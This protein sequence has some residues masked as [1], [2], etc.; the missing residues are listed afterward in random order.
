MILYNNFVFCMLLGIPIVIFLSTRKNKKGVT[1]N[2][3]FI[4]IFLGLGVI[5][6]SLIGFFAYSELSHIIAEPLEMWNRIYFYIAADLF[7]FYLFTVAFL[8]YAEKNIT[9]PVESLSEIA[10]SYVSQESKNGAIIAEKCAELCKN[11]SETGVLAEAFRLMVLDIDNYIDNLTKVT[12]EK[13]RIGAELNVATQIQASMLPC[14]FPAFPERAEFDI[15]ATMQ[16][17][18]EVGG[19][20]YDF[21]LIDND[22]L[23]VVMADVSG[24]GVPAA[25]FMVIAKTLIKN[26]A[27][28]GK[29]PKE[30][31]ETVNNILCEN[32]DAGMF[33]TAFMGYLNI[34]SGKF[35][36]VNAGHNFPLIK[37][38]NKYEFLKTKPAFILAGMENIVYKENELFLKSGDVLFLYT[39]GVT[40]AMNRSYELFSDAKLLETAEKYKDTS[41]LELLPIIKKE[42]DKF[43][44]GAEQADDITMLALKIL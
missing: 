41:P 20:F 23:A 35:T 12:A 7:V 15:Y 42:I 36:F 19:D 2:E 22:N 33:V 27:Q 17:A 44:D 38:Q 40:E 8:W 43:A 32:N 28:L 31:F 34:P 29:S 14:I 26:N 10:K 21:F 1:L 25:L 24:K 5:S 4:L 30:V 6:A 13:E 37:K 9:I 3:R 16:P 18:K 39:D 11:R